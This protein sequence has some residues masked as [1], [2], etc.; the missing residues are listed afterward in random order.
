[1]SRQKLLDLFCGA[2][3]AAMGYHRAGFD[4]VGVDINPQPHYP[5]EFHQA[6]ALEY[7]AAYA[8]EFDAIHASP[9]CQAYSI[10]ASLS[11]KTHP[12]MIE[13]TRAALIATGKP[14]VIENVPGA[15]LIN[16]LVL[17]GTMFGLRVIRHRLF[18]CSPVI[19]WPPM[20]CNHWSKIGKNGFCTMFGKGSTKEKGGNKSMWQ[21]SSGITWMTVGE[22]SQAISPAYTEFIGRQ[23]LAYVRSNQ[24]L[25]PTGDD[26][27]VA[28]KLK[29]GG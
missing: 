10:T 11:N 7:C 27:A 8:H 2:G 22:M 28:S 24:V 19:W 3:G 9:P 29:S 16:P 4:V 25:Q 12:K 15:P 5:F 14:Y 13:L 20:A 17:C 1:M 6:D 26:S 18:E 23:M 21:L